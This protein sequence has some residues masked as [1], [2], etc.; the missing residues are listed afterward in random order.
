MRGEQIAAIAVTEPDAGSDV[1]GIKTHAR[2]DGDDWV[3]N[4]SK[5]FITNSV[6]ADWLCVLART[7]DEGGYAGMSQIIVPTK[8][9][10]TRSA[11]WTSWACT[12]P[13]PV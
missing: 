2:R 9:P 4:G 3:I 6:Q 7:S 10:G 8:T 11:S 5:M 13:T 12:P 1:A